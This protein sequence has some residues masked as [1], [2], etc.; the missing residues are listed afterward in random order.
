MVKYKKITIITTFVSD[1]GDSP[2]SLLDRAV[3]AQDRGFLE[4]LFF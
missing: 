4:S 1:N 2:K 3:E